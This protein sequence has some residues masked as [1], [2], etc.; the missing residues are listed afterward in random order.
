MVPIKD[1][2]EE[3]L[4]V[5]VAVAVAGTAVVGLLAGAGVVALDTVLLWR[6]IVVVVVVVLRSTG[7]VVVGAAA[8]AAAADV[9][10]VVVAA[11][12]VAAVCCNMSPKKLAMGF[13]VAPVP[14]DAA[15]PVDENVGTT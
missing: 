5:A 14:V 4:L 13:A 2:M 3:S 15:A 12:V 1:A 11:V 8:A 9:V 7:S 10:V 6:A